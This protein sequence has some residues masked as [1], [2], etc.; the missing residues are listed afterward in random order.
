MR[1]ILIIYFRSNIEERRSTTTTQ[2]P[3]NTSTLSSAT[4]STT[5][6][7]Q[8]NV[9]K[10]ATTTSRVTPTVTGI[11]KSRAVDTNRKVVGNSSATTTGNV[12]KTRKVV[13]PTSSSSIKPSIS[14]AA[15][16]PTS[17]KSTDVT[18]SAATSGKLSAVTGTKRIAA[19]GGGSTTA[20]VAKTSLT[21]NVVRTSEMQKK[22]SIEKRQTTSSVTLRKSGQ[23][24][25]TTESQKKTLASGDKKSTTASISSTA[26]ASTAK[27]STTV[28]RK[29]TPANPPTNN[30]TTNKRLSSNL[31]NLECIPETEAH[32]KTRTSHIV[33]K[34]SSTTPVGNSKIF[35]KTDSSV[36]LARRRFETS[37]SQPITGKPTE[38]A[39]QS[40]PKIKISQNLF[41]RKDAAQR[42]TQSINTT[43]D[44][45]IINTS[46]TGAN[47]SKTTC[48]IKSEAS[49]SNETSKDIHG[50]RNGDTTPSTPTRHKTVVSSTRKDIFVFFSCHL[51]RYIFCI[52]L[53]MV[54]YFLYLYIDLNQDYF[55]MQLKW[56]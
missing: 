10:P 7:K 41:L 32:A 46:V 19:I 34:A 42:P 51:H 27:K 22:A 49:Q 52:D 40:L 48:D 12:D 17:K 5:N 28:V 53:S 55:C 8:N 14:T 18:P 23:P 39:E 3:D 36:S 29:S 56:I 45:G 33:S 26:T 21:G 44:T 47:T 4:R 13:S 6:N 50:I 2:G 30:D 43:S 20:A 9:S 54:K 15:V 37:N 35:E 1:L 11:T 25:P 24:T 16:K 38:T 31:E